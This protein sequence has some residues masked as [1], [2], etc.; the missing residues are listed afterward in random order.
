MA[1]NGS[2]R[3]VSA[4]IVLAVASAA[5][6]GPAASTPLPPGESVLLD[7]GN[8]LVFGDAGRLGDWREPIERG[9][10]RT[11]ELAA[12]LLRVDR[13]RIDVRA[14]TRYAIPE[15]GFGGRADA[16][17]VRLD[18]DPDSTALP[19]SL[20]TELVPLVAHELHHVARMRT[21][22]YGDNL[23]GAMVSEGLADHF[24]VQVAR[25]DPPLW[26]GALTGAEL[27]EWLGRARPVWLRGGYDHAAWFLGTTPEIPRWTGYA[28]GF[29]LVTRYLEAEPGRRASDLIAE[30]ALS[31]AD[32]GS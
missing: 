3:G 8:V 17:G 30:P 9:V 13:V 22:G 14:G 2:G 5:C 6:S 21:A 1:R 11:L 18:F 28:V 10:A 25:D 16:G 12:P 31:F 26:S 29:E 27:E 32:A 7:G 4:V 15:I 20:E 19:G 24:S 23:L